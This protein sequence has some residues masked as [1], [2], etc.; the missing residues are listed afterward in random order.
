MEIKLLNK[1]TVY[2]IKYV[3]LHKETLFYL[4]NIKLNKHVDQR[5]TV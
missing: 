3:L 5:V 2:Q 1:A 4:D